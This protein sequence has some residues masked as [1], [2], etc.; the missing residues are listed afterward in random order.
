MIDFTK[1]VRTR[2]GKP[3]E[4]LKVLD[5]AL[6]N[7]DRIVGLVL[8]VEGSALHSWKIDGTFYAKQGESMLDLVNAS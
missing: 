7:G 1:P 4:I 5:Q 8:Y 2:R 3:V 6:D